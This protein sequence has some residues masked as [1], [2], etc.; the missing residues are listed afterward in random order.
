MSVD[1]DL[2]NPW[3]FNANFSGALDLDLDEIRIKELAPVEF[4]VSEL[5]DFNFRVK[6]LPV[7]VLKADIGIKELPIIR[8]ESNSKLDVKLDSTS[9]LES[10]SKVDLGLDNIRIR[11]LPTLKFELGFKPVRFHFPIN[12]QWRLTLFGYELFKFNTCGESQVIA[13]DY[14][15]RSTESCS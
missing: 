6:E 15:A 13:E 9:K 2:P 10:N 8:L 14:V 1:V 7:I 12:Y 5:S 3:T 11:E 4:R